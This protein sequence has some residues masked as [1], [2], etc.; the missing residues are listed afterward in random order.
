MYA[1]AT[2][3]TV[4][5]TCIKPGTAA[6]W[7]LN[8]FMTLYRPIFDALHAYLL[9]LGDGRMLTPEELAPILDRFRGELPVES[10]HIE[11]G[12][13]APA[14]AKKLRDDLNRAVSNLRRLL[15]KHDFERANGGGARA[16]ALS[17]AVSG[18][19]D[20][21]GGTVSSGGGVERAFGGAKKA[22]K[23][24]VKKVAKKAGA[25][26]P[27][28]RSASSPRLAKRFKGGMTSAAD[29]DPSCKEM[30][31]GGRTNP[32]T[33]VPSALKANISQCMK[34]QALKQLEI[35]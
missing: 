21:R 4:V 27:R 34:Q 6:V 17:R 2:I 31:A 13:V 32:R 7:T 35:G 8:A 5:K 28:S 23:K 16:R 12:A 19:G 26:L 22:V 9:E 11:D 14:A 1:Q 18:G 20:A 33:G 15:N 24:A 10:A 29:D 3:N 30:V 25:C